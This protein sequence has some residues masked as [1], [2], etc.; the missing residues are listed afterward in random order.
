MNYNTLPTQC[1]RAQGSVKN[2]Q[3]QVLRRHLIGDGT[4]NLGALGQVLERIWEQGNVESS[5][6]R[7]VQEARQRRKAFLDVSEA[8]TGLSLGTRYGRALRRLF[9][10][11]DIVADGLIRVSEH[12]VQLPGVVAS[13]SLELANLA[14]QDYE[15]DT[16]NKVARLNRDAD[17]WFFGVSRGKSTKLRK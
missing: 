9:S 15:L 4:S 12:Q 2:T 7:I 14:G 16:K 10:R 8:L 5:S 3:F 11:Y 17:M 6:A 13:Y 1:K